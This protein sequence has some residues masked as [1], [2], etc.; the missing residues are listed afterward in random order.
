[1]AAIEE[2]EEESATLNLSDTSTLLV[3]SDACSTLY[4]QFC[5]GQ[6]KHNLEEDALDALR[7]FEEIC[8]DHLNI[9]DQI[10]RQRTSEQVSR[11]DAPLVSEEALKMLRLERDTW[12]LARILVGDRVNKSHTHP[13]ES[14]ET[15]SSGEILSDQQVIEKLYERCESIRQ[16]Q[17]VV[18][19]CEQN[20]LDDM[21]SVESEDKIEFYTQGPHYWENTLHSLKTGIGIGGSKIRDDT[22]ESSVMD[23]DASFHASKTG[24]I[25]H[26]LDKED[27][28]RLLR[29]TFRNIRAGQLDSGIELCQKLG[30]HW[31]AGI[32]QAWILHHDPNFSP[33]ATT[34][35]SSTGNARR[36]LFKFICWSSASTAKN[37]SLYE[38]AI[39]GALSGNATAMLPACPTWMDKLWAYFRSSIDVQVEQELKANR[40][41]KPS[42]A[43]VSG[44]LIPSSRT[45]TELPSEYWSNNKTPFE[46]YREIEGL[47]SD[48]E[49]GTQEKHYFI[50]QK[51]LILNDIDTLLESMI[52]L[53]GSEE[54]ISL[55]K[56]SFIQSFST[57]IVKEELDAR[58]QMLRFFAHIVLFLRSVGLID[59]DIRKN[60]FTVIVE[61]YVNFLIDQKYI[62]LVS[63]YVSKMPTDLHTY[64]YSK[65]LKKV[66]D[67]QDRKK[68][69]EFARMAG[70]DVEEITKSVVEK[71]KES[72]HTSSHLDN[73]STGVDMS[74]S[75]I[76]SLPTDEEDRELINGL[77]WLYLG[78]QV[79]YIEMLRQS[80]GLLRSFI[81]AGKIEAARD[82]KRRVPSDII[83]GVYQAWKKKTGTQELSVELKNQEREYLC[84]S[85]FFDALE[86]IQDWIE[87]LNNTKPQPPPKLTSSKFAEKIAYEQMMKEYEAELKKWKDLLCRR[88]SL[89]AEKILGVLIFPLGWLRDESSSAPSRREQDVTRTQELATLRKKFVPQLTFIL[90]TVLHTSNL[91]RSCIEIADIIADE[92][93]QLYAEFAPEQMKDLLRKI[94][95]SSTASLTDGGDAF[96]QDKTNDN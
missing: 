14:M 75:G 81:L 50:V 79:Q 11:F 93:Y 69:L 58:H 85:F 25:V 4:Q 84:F 59:N 19:W 47:L 55:A 18:D 33:D 9:L 39:Y 41:E 65:L 87:Y 86:S 90:H 95:E 88:A 45:S 76:L 44:T 3:K 38:K 30:Y 78:G 5:E 46:I 31:L 20:F 71:M 51:F 6:Q 15:G 22:I 57:T 61:A 42:S 80:N 89:T 73:T 77:E 94:Q 91:Y 49:W 56:K 13:E 40:D 37:M 72:H 96:G 24:R 62:P 34:R 16:M 66:T 29:F 17:L 92:K 28:N 27:E 48:H 53:L 10:K 1:M 70:L 52:D 32:L 26:E 68:C 35:L 36:D 67:K 43:R 23:P 54:E 7:E 60:Y 21:Q 74:L 83:P 8:C 12:R 64:L 63:F 2:G 82:V